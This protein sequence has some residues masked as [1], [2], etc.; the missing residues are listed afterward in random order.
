MYSKI[1]NI[2]DRKKVLFQLCGVFLIVVTGSYFFIGGTEMTRFVVRPSYTSK[3]T[4]STPQVVGS[5]SLLNLEHSLVNNSLQLHESTVAEHTESNFLL[6]VHYQH[7]TTASF[8]SYIQLAKLAGLLNLSSVVPYVHKL[9]LEGGANYKDKRELKLTSLYNFTEMKNFMKPCCANT[10]LETFEEFIDGASRHI[11]LVSFITSIDKHQYRFL[12]GR[13]IVEFSCSL[14]TPIVKSSRKTLNSWVLDKRYFSCYRVVLLDARPKHALPL[15]DVIHVLSS[16]V[17]EQLVKFGSATVVLDTWNGMTGQASSSFFSYVPGFK[18]DSRCTDTRTTIEHSN[19]VISASNHFMK[20]F[21]LTQQ[22]VGVH[23]RGERL[24]RDSNWN[25]E[26]G[27]HCLQQLHNFLH[28]HTVMGDSSHYPVYVI[29][30]LGHYGSVSCTSKECRKGRPKLLSKLKQLKF[31]VVYFDPSTFKSFP[32]SGIFAS[33]VEREYL[34]HVQMLVTVGQG[35]FQQTIVNRFLKYS[36]GN[37]KNLHR[38][39]HPIIP[40]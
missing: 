21:N 39:C 12:K 15:S 32:K 17:Q 24:L 18:L 22:A 25:I 14:N 4:S 20:H 11:V 23:I 16:L 35:G 34:S 6:S 29:H 5:A 3:N 13:N 28:N 8:I 19:L 10:N 33:F 27:I 30:D 26:Y 9:G 31:Q 7:Q 36:S 40:P 37:D 2:S 1:V 38:I